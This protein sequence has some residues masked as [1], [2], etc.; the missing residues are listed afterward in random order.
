[1]IWSISNRADP[2]ARE[3]ADRHYN[4]QKPGTSQFAP[5]GSCVVFKALT[6][7]GRA[8]WV[9]SWPLAEWVRHA[10]PGAWICSAFRNEGAGRASD[11]VREAVAATRAFYGESPA[12]GMITFVNRAKVRPTMVRGKPVYGW[13]FRKAGFVDAG[14]T[15][16]GLLALQ[17]LPG[18]MPAP[19]GALGTQSSLFDWGVTP[20]CEIGRAGRY[21]AG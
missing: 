3:I 13:C 18:A 1:M 14:E 21:G 10:W 20:R 16:G 8:F 5:T 9:T 19:S 11:M 2:F 12:L 15:A 17:I 6:P 4:R 7:T